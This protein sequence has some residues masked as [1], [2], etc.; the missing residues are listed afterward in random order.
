MI[1]LEIDFKTHLYVLL[2][3]VIL[4]S[5]QSGLKNRVF[6]VLTKSSMLEELSLDVKRKRLAKS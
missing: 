1:S 6:L 4:F 5:E 3:P 2:T